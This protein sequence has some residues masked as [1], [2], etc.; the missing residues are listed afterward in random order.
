MS[1]EEEEDFDLEEIERQAFEK[2]AR[3]KASLKSHLSKQKNVLCI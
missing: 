2:M 3:R 1:E